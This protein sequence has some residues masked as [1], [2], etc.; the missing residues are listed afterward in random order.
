MLKGKI[1]EPLIKLSNNNRLR[2]GN[3]LNLK[4]TI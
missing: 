4:I 3:I 1:L 2:R